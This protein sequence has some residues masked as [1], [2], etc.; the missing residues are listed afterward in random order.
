MLLLFPLMGVG[1]LLAALN[2]WRNYRYFG[3]SP[4]RLDPVNGQAGGQ[5]GGEILPQPL[6]AL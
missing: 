5:A 1:M 3:P 6:L 2:G 4:L